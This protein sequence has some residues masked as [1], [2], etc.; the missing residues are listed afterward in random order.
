MTKLWELAKTK[1]IA[2]EVDLGV[3][4]GEGASDS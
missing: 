3:S 4:A 1:A 2:R